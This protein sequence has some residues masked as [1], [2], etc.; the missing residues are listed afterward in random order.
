MREGINTSDI[1]FRPRVVGVV[2]VRMDLD[3]GMGS[4]RSR[5]A[6]TLYTGPNGSKECH[7][8]L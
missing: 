7:V 5:V 6:S 2:D 8:S 3:H 1:R 4:Y